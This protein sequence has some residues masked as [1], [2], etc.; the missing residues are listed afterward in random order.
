[1]NPKYAYCDF[2]KAL[3]NA[4]KS[5]FADAEII[6]YLFRFKQALRRDM[7]SKLD[8]SEEQV[9]IAMEKNCLNILAVISKHEIKKKGIP[10][11]KNAV[12]QIELTAADSEKWE[13]F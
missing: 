10:H 4:A 1:M 2:E 5:Q 12:F 6:S 11:A 3:I 8:I 13:K 9:G 7:I